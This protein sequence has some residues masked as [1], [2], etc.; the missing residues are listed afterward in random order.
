MAID[1]SRTDTILRELLTLTKTST[2]TVKEQLKEI[3][4]EI[5]DMRNVLNGTDGKPGFVARTYIL[6]Q[7]VLRLEKGQRERP[8]LAMGPGRQHHRI[9]NDYGHDQHGAALRQVDLPGAGQRIC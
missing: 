5:D 9:V 6:E 8:H 4:R 1:D 2:Q 3:E 7:N